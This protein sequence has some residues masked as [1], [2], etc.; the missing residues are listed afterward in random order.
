[1]L[2]IRTAQLEAL[3]ARL[4]PALATR[5]TQYLRRHHA[6]AAARLSD[7]KLDADVARS[8]ARAQRY[9]LTREA[10]LVCFAAL[11]LEI[12]PAFDLHPRI[13]AALQ[14]AGLRPDERFERMLETTTEADW[15]D[16]RALGVADGADPFE[17]MPVGPAHVPALAALLRDIGAPPVP[18]G[19]MA[20]WVTR[21]VQ[22]R[23]A[24]REFAFVITMPTG[25][26]VGMCT[27]RGLEE[28]ERRAELSYWVG[29]PYRNRGY[30]TTAVRRVAAFGFA[31][32]GLATIAAAIAPDNAA[33]C[34]VLEKVGGLRAAD[35]DRSGEDRA[36]VIYC[37]RE[38]D[39]RG[40]AHY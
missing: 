2:T 10:S 19:D 16:A 14:E 24:G 6:A 38:E 8:L 22:A 37:L 40:T 34:R 28:T 17:L 18:P 1:M 25:V 4:L 35:G 29:R 26:P 3:R 20:A 33:S 27:L 31:R 9:G 30:A 11:A 13:Q 39:W 23:A 21:S 36:A 15:Q 5:A 32:V 7:V 12:G